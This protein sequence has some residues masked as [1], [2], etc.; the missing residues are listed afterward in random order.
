MNLTWK[1]PSRILLCAGLALSIAAVAQA[2]TRFQTIAPGAL[3]TAAARG[4]V[5]QTSDGGTISVGEIRSQLSRGYDIYVV[6]SNRCGQVEWSMTYDIGGNDFGRKIRQVSNGSV[7]DGYIIVGSTEN[8]NSCCAEASAIIARPSSDVFL[9]RI[10][11]VGTVLWGKT[12]GGRANDEGADVQV[13]T[14]GGFVVAGRTSSFGLGRISGYLIRTNAAGS[15][16]WGRSYGE[17]VEY[18]NSCTVATDGDVVAVGASATNTTE[19]LYAV[20]VY[21]SDGTP[22]WAWVYPIRGTGVARSVIS[23]IRETFVLGG[24]VVLDR[25]GVGSR[26]GYLLRIDGGGA[27]MFGRAFTGANEVYDDEI[28]EVRQTPNNELVFTG[29]LTE[30]PGGFGGRDLWLGHVDAGFN[31]IGAHTAHGGRGEDEGFSVSFIPR[32][33]TKRQVVSANGVTTSFTRGNE[34]L[35]LVQATFPGGISG[36]NDAEVKVSDYE[37]LPRMLEAVRLAPNALVQCT[38]RVTATATRGYRNL[39]TSCPTLPPIDEPDLGEVA[40]RN[41][42]EVLPSTT[43]IGTMAQGVLV[44]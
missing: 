42:G 20:R 23:S 38:S 11:A 15:V 22:V 18:F 14:D 19:S 9:L 39:C 34:N 4:G 7:T 36:C 26:D 32:D 17:G 25:L 10:N 44:W 28:A 41:G 12:Y 6:K 43:A 30:A 8:A 1:L 24:Y 5:L 21:G 16:I 31:T 35:Y 13:Y 3:G 29:Y 2:Q 27:P 40:P 37:L 33:D